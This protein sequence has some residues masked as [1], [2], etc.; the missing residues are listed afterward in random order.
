MKPSEMF[1]PDKK[2]KPVI[3]GSAKR[4]TAAAEDITSVQIATHPPQRLK[5]PSQLELDMVTGMDIESEVEEAVDEGITSE[6]PTFF[7]RLY[8]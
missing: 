6:I 7:F 2:M 1:R 5:G 4:E 3:P 8:K